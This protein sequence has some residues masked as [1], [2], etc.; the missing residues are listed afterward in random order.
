[1]RI[2]TRHAAA[3]A[4]ACG[5]IAAAPLAGQAS[6][7][8]VA[9]RYLERTF[10]QRYDEL[11]DL[12]AEDAVFHDPTADVFEGPVADGPVRGAA[13]IVA[14]QKSWGIH[15]SEFDVTRH[16]TV[17][18]RA[19][20]EGTLNIRYGEEAPWIAIPFITVLR[21]EDGRLTER[22][23]FAEY[24]ESF[25]L[26]DAFDANTASTA[27][28]AA[29]YLRAYL[30]ADFAT[31]EALLDEGARFQDPTAQV[32]GPSSGR[33]LDGRDAIL[34]RRRATFGNVRAFDLEVERT[35]I[36]NHHAVFI[37]TTTY[38][39]ANGRRF[40]QPAVFVV[41]VRDGRVTRHWDFVDYT[42]GPVG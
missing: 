22:T 12:Y 4:I 14:L 1:M 31:Q 19:L 33:L 38:T 36:G 16:F 10:A 17:G 8:E 2:R 6:T 34:D 27:D 32:Y 41:E 7:E 15:A 25:Q 3:T 29:R 21:V 23:D 26:G 9:G 28:V 18:E 5:T 11:V 42:V 35:F 37:G 39:L 13:E 24:V 20:Y 30:D 40:E